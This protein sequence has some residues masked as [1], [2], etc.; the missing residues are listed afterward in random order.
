MERVMVN[1]SDVDITE[2]PYFEEYSTFKDGFGFELENREFI[3]TYLPPEVKARN[4]ALMASLQNMES[5]SLKRKADE[6]IKAQ[7]LPERFDN[8]FNFMADKSNGNFAHFNQLWTPIV[9]QAREMNTQAKVTVGK[10]SHDVYDVDYGIAESLMHLY[11]SADP[12]AEYHEWIERQRQIEVDINTCG[13]TEEEIV[14]RNTFITFLD[15]RE[16]EMKRVMMLYAGAAFNPNCRQQIAAQEKLKFLTFKLSELRRLRERTANTKAYADEKEKVEKQERQ[17]HIAATT[18]GFVALGIT[19][20][21]A[22]LGNK[23]L[24]EKVNT[25]D[26]EHGV[27][28]TFLQQRPFTNTKDEAEAKINAA[29]MHRSQI[30]DMLLS[31]SREG[32][33]KDAWL[34]K[35]ENENLSASERLKS[36]VRNIRGF[37][38]SRYNE[39]TNSY[40]V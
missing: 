13:T 8:F 3:R 7:K 26:L 32:L 5:Q 27:G 34:E 6:F 20:E 10:E 36:R 2:T 38:V 35:Q 22:S 1:L 23:R 4:D 28:Q 31:M 24:N 12:K 29:K 19:A 17:Q 37:D 14:E 15:D 9:W 30:R 39:Y 11:S 25:A 18:A 16:T 21:M 33:S 40:P